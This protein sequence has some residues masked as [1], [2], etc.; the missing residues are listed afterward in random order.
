M[1]VREGN[2]EFCVSA[3]IRGTSSL[4]RFLNTLIC[5]SN[6][7]HFY[8]S[9]VCPL[10]WQWKVPKPFRSD[11][12]LQHLGQYLMLPNLYPVF[13]SIHKSIFHKEMFVDYQH[14]IVVGDFF[15]N[16]P[17]SLC[18]WSAGHLNLHVT[19]GVNPLLQR[20][21]RNHVL[22]LFSAM[23]PE[24]GLLAGKVGATEYLCINFKQF[25]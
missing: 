9:S 1:W 22:F 20:L 7:L 11:V 5:P 16:I 24:S 13:I 3:V 6:N 25:T 15:W 4:A 2:L 14:H 18:I 19:L 10:K 8:F 12:F 17:S 21:G 23:K